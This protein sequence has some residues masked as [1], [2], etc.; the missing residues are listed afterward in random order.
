MVKQRTNI[1]KTYNYLIRLAIILLT[2]GFIYRQIFMERKLEDIAAA[3]YTIAGQPFALTMM[4]LVVLLMLL[5]WGLESV[6]WK[7]LISKIE[8]IS[9]LRAYQAVLTGVSVSLFTPNRTGDYLGRVFILDKAN[10]VEGVLITVI[11]SMSQLVI[12]LN[13]GIIALLAF[14]DEYI[15]IPYRIGEY[16]FSGLIFTGPAVVFLVFL[17]FFKIRILSELISK[18]IPT[19]WRHFAEYAGVFAKYRPKELLIVL[20]LS[21]L[22]YIVF[23]AQF[24]FLLWI[25]G[26][27]LPLREA[28]V[29]IPV[30]YLAMT[31]VPSIA[32]I[33]LGIRGSVSLFVIGLY[34]S[35]HHHFNPDIELGII[36][37]AT[38]LWL[39]NLIIPAIMGTFFVFSLKFFRK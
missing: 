18:R 3:I 35:T 39:V 23:G 21:L 24:Y 26:V 5:N 17:L 9:I 14:V 4:Y 6:K 20:L 37:A 2:Y 31:M 32:L 13:V 25:F 8:W 1:R 10:R 36:T 19:K 15:R 16:V 33:D 30:I 22:R 29:L 7:L 11:G 27:Q 34:F 12:T 28:L 38:V